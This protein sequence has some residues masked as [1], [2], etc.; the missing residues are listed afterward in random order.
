[1]LPMIDRINKMRA[2]RAKQALKKA[3]GRD[4]L[5]DAPTDAVV[6]LLADLRHFCT[7][8]A[9]DFEECV[10]VSDTYHK[11]ELKWSNASE[12]VSWQLPPK[13]GCEGECS[14]GCSSNQTP[15]ESKGN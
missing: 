7:R 2:K 1:M 14:G 8:N 11:D 5:I 10:D 6:G 4:E 3:Y 9:I 13:K 12:E 15:D